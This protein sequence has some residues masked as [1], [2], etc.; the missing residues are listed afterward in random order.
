MFRVTRKFESSILTSGV[1]FCSDVIL[2]SPQTA[3]FPL[4]LLRSIYRIQL[5]NPDIAVLSSAHLPRPELDP[6]ALDHQPSPR[7]FQPRYQR[8]GSSWFS[9]LPWLF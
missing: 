9:I 7:H 6:A 3:P 8:P 1:A 2:L 4:N 5:L